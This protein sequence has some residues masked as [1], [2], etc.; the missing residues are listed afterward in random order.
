[1]RIYICF[2]ILH[3]HTHLHT[4]TY[5][6]IYNA[7]IYIYICA[8]MYIHKYMCIYKYIH[9]VAAP[10]T[11]GPTCCLPRL[12]RPVGPAAARQSSEASSARHSNNMRGCE[13]LNP[14]PKEPRHK[15]GRLPNK[16]NKVPPQF[17]V[18]LAQE[19]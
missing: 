6:Y 5:I 15:G 7:H 18:S 17:S 3:T 10:P 11:M 13:A 2:C 14:I 12:A 8:H 4:P 19:G 16:A 9:I 1:M